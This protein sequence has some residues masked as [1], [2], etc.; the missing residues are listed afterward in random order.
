M[1]DLIPTEG[2]I[3]W[4][5]GLFEGEGW[6]SL[7][8]TK[9][10][11]YPKLGVQMADEGI[12]RRFHQTIGMGR[13]YGPYQKGPTQKGTIPKPQYQWLASGREARQIIHRLLPYLG[14]RRRA[15]AMEVMSS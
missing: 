7:S 12:V 3:M 11:C 2:Q 10:H 6:I 4:A 1:A 15:R 8:R 13:V 5:A 14:S 9:G